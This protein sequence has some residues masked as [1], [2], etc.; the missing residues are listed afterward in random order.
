MY[1][2]D[3]ALVDY[4]SYRD[5]V[6][7]FPAGIV[8]LQGG[9][10]RGKTNLVEAISY[11]SAFSS[12][13][14]GGTSALVRIDRP[15]NEQPGGAVIRLRV[16]GDNRNDL[17]E[18][19]IARGRANR[20]RFNRGQVSP[21]ELLGNLRS[22]VFSPEDLAILRGDPSGRRGLLDEMLVQLKP[23]YLGLK[24]DFDRT[25]KQ[26]GA[27]LKNLSRRG[28]GANVDAEAELE[29]WNDQSAELSAQIAEHRQA[30][31]DALIPLVEKYYS[32]ISE[33]DR[34]ADLRYAQRYESETVLKTG[35]VVS[36]GRV[37][38]DSADTLPVRK[39]LYV[40][41][42]AE[43]QQ[44]EVRRGVNL[45]G[46][47]RDDLEI[48]LDGLPT[49]GFA[50]HGELWS[51]ALALRLAQLELLAAD[52]DSPVLILDDVFAELDSVRRVGLMNLIK[53]VEQVFV[54]VAVPEDLPEG[55]VAT[56]YEVTRQ[57]DGFSHVQQIVGDESPA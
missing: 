52:E 28:G 43:K 18:L 38:G 35:L 8:V 10:G 48:T 34:Q 31:V 6:V 9:N 46:A 57:E 14:P 49:K 51:T 25:L 11:L 1:V 47:H 3:L 53:G 40:Q 24:Q 33:Q 15:E 20:A 29:V 21:R 17:L 32:Q 27:V 19:E 39:E 13:R 5:L 16:Q 2:S 26:R 37:E 41:Q 23:H 54:T 55:L 22:V 56:H 45:V 30:L 36:G 50:S 42:M 12:H 4:R 44:E 7:S